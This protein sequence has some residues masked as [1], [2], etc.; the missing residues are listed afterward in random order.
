M[1]QT[2]NTLAAVRTE[3]IRRALRERGVMRVEELCQE[4]GV[5]PATVR[6][7][8]TDLA[9]RGVIQ[10]VHGGALSAESPNHEPLFDDKASILSDEK[11]AIAKKALSFVEPKGSVFLDGGS[12]VLALA[13]LLGDMSGLTVV[14]N[15]VRVALLLSGK[16]PRLILTGGELRRLSQTF[17][18]PLS[19]HL[20]DELHVD[21]AFMGT[22]GVSAEGGLT[23]TD[24]A[25][26]YTKS[27]VLA[28]AGRAIL[29]ADHSKIGKVSFSHF[30]G[31]ETIHTLITD[32]K[33]PAAMMETLRKRGI[34]VV[35]ATKSVA[36]SKSSKF[37]PVQ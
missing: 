7:D 36:S 5:S 21:T 1:I 8:L 32:S 17:V 30:G 29:L 19:R 11:Q 22:I 28:R 24:P 13:R 9:R 23:T 33:A 20:L 31:V 26:A 18:G 34:K 37:G 10:K 35:V 16:G 2:A 6:R 27:L 3:Q 12:T 15:S 14:T 25:E 4:L